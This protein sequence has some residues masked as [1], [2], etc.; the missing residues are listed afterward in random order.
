MGARVKTIW[1]TFIGD[2]GKDPVYRVVW[3]EGEHIPDYGQALNS[4]GTFKDRKKA[5]MHAD[6]LNGNARDDWH[7]T[8]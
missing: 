1:P 7:D 4:P 2:F 6:T 5:Q 3:S 8:H